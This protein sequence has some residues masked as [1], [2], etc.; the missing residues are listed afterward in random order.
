MDAFDTSDDLPEELYSE[1]EERL[2]STFIMAKP[3]GDSFGVTAIFLFFIFL[4]SQ[5]YWQNVL[6]WAE[7]L[8]AVNNKIFV[9]GQWWRVFTATLIHA[10]IGHLL[11]NMYMLGIFTFFVYGHFGLKVHPGATFL[12]AGLVNLI[13]ISTYAPN[14]QL[15]GASGLVYLLGGFWLTLYLFVQRLYPFTNRLVRVCGI[16]LM[17]F[18]P[19]SFEP[20]TS[21]RTHAIGFAVGC[22][23]GLLYFLA[24][25]KRLR[26]YEK[27]KIIY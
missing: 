19:T 17:V 5:L 26:S 22:A 13:A 6:G 16:A 12:A 18:F 2:T 25:K 24:N 1:P 9:E 23:M 10:D 7:Y 15:L 27:Y 4:V 14:T 21:Y 8:P 11:S 20:T 3:R